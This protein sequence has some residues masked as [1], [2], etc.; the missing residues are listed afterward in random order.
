[1]NQ[2]ARADDDEAGKG[3]GALLLYLLNWH[4]ILCLSQVSGGIV[5][6][7]TARKRDCVYRPVALLTKW[8]VLLLPRRSPNTHK[9]THTH[10]SLSVFLS[11]SLSV[12]LSPSHTRFGPLHT[13]THTHTHTQTLMLIRICRINTTL[14]LY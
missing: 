14:M 13:H 9:H 6:I 4:S 12:A 2:C 1:M 11:L 3:L 10:L 8:R 5:L 7:T